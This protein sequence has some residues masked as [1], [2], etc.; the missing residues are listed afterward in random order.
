MTK[1][2][3]KTRDIKYAE[4]T[5]LRPQEKRKMVSLHEISAMTDGVLIRCQRSARKLS[6]S[7]SLPHSA[8][9]RGVQIVI[10]IS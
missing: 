5:L 4:D 8:R 9:G 7:I 6:R 2:G 3:N 1:P 10:L